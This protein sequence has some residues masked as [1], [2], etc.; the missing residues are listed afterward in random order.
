MMP[1]CN[2]GVGM[3]MGF[4]DVCLTPAAPA[5]LPIPYPNMAMNVMGVPFSPNVFIGFMPA[6]TMA[7]K[8]PMTMGDDAG[9]ANPLFKQMGQYTMGNPTVLVNC[10]PAVSMLCPTT[11][12]M[13]NNPVGA[14]LVPSITTTFY[15]DASASA[16]GSELSLEGLR[17][18]EQARSGRT[19]VSGSLVGGAPSDNGGS[20]ASQRVAYVRIERFAARTSQHVFSLLRR[21]GSDKIAAL[22]IDLRR[23]PGGDANAAI[24]LASDFLAAGAVV[25]VRHD[26][27][28]DANPVKSRNKRPYPWPVVVLVDGGTASAAEIFAGALAH[29]G[30]AR[31]M[32]DTTMGKATAQRVLAGP[33]GSVHYATVARYTLPDGSPLRLEPECGGLAE[34]LQVAADL[35]GCHD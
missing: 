27:D 5:P 29:H 14:V 16:L 22:V 4:P 26:P 34:A 35:Q 23:N 30:R 19:A 7:A 1:A 32:G 3:N 2:N 13:M 6:L 9:V 24:E 21:L 8:E 20:E 28:G 12:N 17:V 25:A 10:C 31:L 15:T 33:A 18:L 11:G